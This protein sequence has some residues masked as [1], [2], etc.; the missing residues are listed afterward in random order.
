M[1]LRYNCSISEE[2][3]WVLKQKE[4]QF[5]SILDIQNFTME[6]THQVQCK[7]WNRKPLQDK[8]APA[9]FSGD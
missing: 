4:K 9:V 2:P 1:K 8:A 6:R 5:L 3:T 7:N